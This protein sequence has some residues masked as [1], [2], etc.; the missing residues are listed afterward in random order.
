LIPY[1]FGDYFWAAVDSKIIGNLCVIFS[2]HSIPLTLRVLGCNAKFKNESHARVFVFFS[3][4]PSINTPITCTKQFS[5][6]FSIS[7]RTHSPTPQVAP[8]YAKA[9]IRTTVATMATAKA[10]GRTISPTV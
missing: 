1:G 4:F 2:D 5:T 6:Q 7:L 10:I 8:R 9:A 3:S